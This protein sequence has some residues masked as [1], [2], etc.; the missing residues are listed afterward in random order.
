MKSIALS[1]D[2]ASIDY[3][4]LVFPYLR[5]LNIPSTLFVVAGFASGNVVACYESCNFKQIIELSQSGIVEIASHGYR[6]CPCESPEEIQRSLQILSA[7]TGELKLG[8]A[9][10]HEAVPEKKFWKNRKLCAELKYVRLRERYTRIPICLFYKKRYDKTGDKKWLLSIHERFLKTR[11]RKKRRGV[12]VIDSVQ[13]RE[14]FS[15]EDIYRLLCRSRDNRLIVLQF[16]TVYVGKDLPSGDRYP[17]GAW[18]FER[19]QA[20]L[21]LI[22]KD[23]N[24]VFTKIGDYY[25]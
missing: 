7:C 13:I 10:P 17:V 9:T 6:H 8:Y 2:D 3:Y 21:S 5:S 18:P 14:V 15:A 25:R 11:G 22:A 24:F 23:S 16:H 4:Q 12:P 19:F 20:L 1:F